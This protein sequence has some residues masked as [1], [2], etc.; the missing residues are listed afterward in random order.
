MNVSSRLRVGVCF[1]IIKVIYFWFFLNVPTYAMIVTYIA[2]NIGS[3]VSTALEPRHKEADAHYLGPI[4]L[5]L[6]VSVWSHSFQ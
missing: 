6:L 4:G 5:G 2:S 3:F 1:I